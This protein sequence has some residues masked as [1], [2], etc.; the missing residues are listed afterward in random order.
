MTVTQPD[1]P[2]PADAREHA[3]MV[4]AVAAIAE[5]QLGE[6]ESERARRALL[7]D[8]LS[9]LRWLIAAPRSERT[10][11]VDRVLHSE[12]DDLVEGQVVEYINRLLRGESSL[13]A[14]HA[15]VRGRAQSAIG[16]AWEVA[17]HLHSLADA[18]VVREASPVHRGELP[19]VPAVPAQRPESEPLPRR[20]PGRP[21]PLFPPAPPESPVEQT[22]AIALRAV[23][24]LRVAG[25][26]TAASEAALASLIGPA[27]DP[28]FAAAA[29]PQAR[30]VRAG[31]TARL[32]VVPDVDGVLEELGM[33]DASEAV[34]A[35]PKAE[36]ASRQ[37]VSRG[38]DDDD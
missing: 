29:L 25:E 36:G 31:D 5:T 27:P 9:V 2:H 33:G 22:G 35:S 8:G 18:R 20:I 28:T 3:H 14:R 19:P 13:M 7:E 30:A 26:S 24:A 32:P 10:L 21:E 17:A 37:A 11:E 12:K 23:E 15:M 16:S 38:A 34:V 1:T 6:A 4:S